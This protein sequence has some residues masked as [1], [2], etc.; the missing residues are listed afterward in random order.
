MTLL[1]PVTIDA[2]TETDKEEAIFSLVNS[3][4]FCERKCRFLL[5]YSSVS[6]AFQVSIDQNSLVSIG[7]SS[8]IVFRHI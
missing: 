3:K 8:P 2:N 4:A 5:L 7:E 1:F 6:T